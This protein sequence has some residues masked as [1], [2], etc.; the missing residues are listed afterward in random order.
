MKHTTAVRPLTLLLT[1]CATA[2]SHQASTAPPAYVIAE[3]AVTDSVGYRGYLAAISPIVERFH[4]T[5][6]VRA[7]K[8]LQIEGASPNGRIVVIAF[9][10][11]AAAKAFEEASESISAGEIRHRTAVSRIFVVEGSAP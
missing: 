2:S 4:G 10:G 6:L 11:F 7:G 1:A 9:P 8:T 3:I 5:Y